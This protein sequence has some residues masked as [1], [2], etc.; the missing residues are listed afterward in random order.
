MPRFKKVKADEPEV[1][2]M[3]LELA[4]KFS[5]ME[6]YVGERPLKAETE[7]ALRADIIEGYIFPFFWAYTI[8]KGV[9]MR[10]NGGQSSTFLANN[11]EYIRDGMFAVIS[12]VNCKNE[13]EAMGYHSRLDAQE[14]ARSKADAITSVLAINKGT[15]KLS[16]FVSSRVISA[17]NVLKPPSERLKRTRD[18]ALALSENP[19]NKR[20]ASQIEYLYLMRPKQFRRYFGKASVF[21]CMVQM[22]RLPRASHSKVT[23]FW[24]HVRDGVAPSP[25]ALTRQL[26]EFLETAGTEIRHR[27]SRRKSVSAHEI[28]Y[29]IVSAWNVYKDEGD[30]PATTIAAYSSKLDVPVVE[31]VGVKST[32]NEKRDDFPSRKSIVRK[33]AKSPSHAYAR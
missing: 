12:K 20:V 23:E 11:T 28:A 31:A 4:Q 26:G 33:L 17:I 32:V 24:E 25:D 1:V 14:L 3:T 10:L 19:G 22:Y 21:T 8:I 9:L 15:R 5:E 16:K 30:Y 7:E 27:N 6:Q 29:R 18:R 13:S 2:P